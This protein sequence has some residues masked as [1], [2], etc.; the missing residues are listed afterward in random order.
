M[1]VSDLGRNYEPSMQMSDLGKYE[2]KKNT[3][4]SGFVT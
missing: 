3:V 1:Q 2:H 4:I